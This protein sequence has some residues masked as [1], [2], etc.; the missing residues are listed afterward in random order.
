MK[1]TYT[2]TKSGILLASLLVFTCTSDPVG[3]E[4]N[5][6]SVIEQESGISTVP[7]EES[8]DFF[9]ASNA[10]KL[11]QP[12][13][14]FD[15]T[16]DLKTLEQVTLS[17]TEA[18][19]NIAKAT[20]KFENVETSVLQINID[21][22]LQTVLFNVIPQNNSEARTETTAISGYNFTGNIVITD[23]SGIVMNN[24]AYNSG[25]LLGEINLNTY[26]TN[27]DPCWGIGCGIDLEEVVITT[28][29]VSPYYY[30][31]ANHYSAYNNVYQW[32]RSLNNYSTMGTAYANYYRELAIEEFEKEIENE[33]TGK[34]KCVY[35]KLF[36]IGMTS[37]NLITETLIAF[38]DGN[39]GDFNNEFHLIYRAEANLTNSSGNMLLG[40]FRRVNN[41]Y[42]VTLNAS[43]I[44]NRSS[45]E[46]AT[47]ILHESIHALLR[48]HYTIGND[49][50]LSLFGE[51]MK[52]TNSSNDITHAIMREH[53]IARMARVLKQF[54]NNRE[55]IDFYEDL[56]WE[57]LH[58]FLTQEEIDRILDTL[59]L[60]RYSD[61]DCN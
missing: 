42:I 33:L 15:L 49:S 38:G 56:A 12:N 54:D 21:G 2:I 40:R 30:A 8:L 25:N 19:L 28:P 53:Y 57:G 47:T 37:H 60:A 52:N 31:Y 3:N 23:L 39:F 26:N 51:Y 44:D 11:G 34:A 55:N 58:Q 14:T 20:T 61:T 36:G 27:P 50:F 6:D 32:N 4:L 48:R 16:I 10:E 13:N 29:S 59:Q 22:K 9:K 46:I 45:L 17:N 5:L 1:K 7:L 24:F 35:E 41:D 43:Q 18:K